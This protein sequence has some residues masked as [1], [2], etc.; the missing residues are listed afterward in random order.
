MLDAA[1]G[2]VPEIMRPAATV[3][4]AAHL[5]KLFDEGR[6]PD[7]VQRPGASDRRPSEPTIR[8]R[9]S[10]SKPRR[11]SRDPAEGGGSEPPGAASRGGSRSPASFERGGQGRGAD[12][13]GGG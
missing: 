12:S 5:D 8:L 13:V 2:E 10:A 3:T 6:L 11:Q 7:G 4:L 1:W 9:A